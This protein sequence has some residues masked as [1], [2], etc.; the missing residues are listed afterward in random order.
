MYIVRALV[1]WG[2]ISEYVVVPLLHNGS[3]PRHKNRANGDIVHKMGNRPMMRLV[4]MVGWDGH[5]GH[6]S[7]TRRAP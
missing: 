1:R 5:T 3:R 4:Y 7:G 6:P 2:T